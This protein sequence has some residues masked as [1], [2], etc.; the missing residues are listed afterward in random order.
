MTESPF[1][2]TIAHLSS[3]VAGPVILRVTQ[4][5]SLMPAPSFGQPIMGDIACML[6]RGSYAGA[7]PPPPDLSPAPAPDLSPPLSS[8]GFLLKSSQPVE[9]PAARTS[10]RRRIEMN[11]IRELPLF[12]PLLGGAAE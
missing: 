1:A 3:M 6:S 8:A 9:S 2:P 10:A 11:R 4:R 5:P 7:P 12:E